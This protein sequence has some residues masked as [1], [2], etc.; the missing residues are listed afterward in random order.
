MY[1]H[2]YVVLGNNERRVDY[3][4]KYNTASPWS[5]IVLLNRDK[6]TSS[7]D[8]RLHAAPEKTQKWNKN[9]KDCK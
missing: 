6:A 8:V 5:W 9:K 7:E 2:I 4:N 1:M 3:R